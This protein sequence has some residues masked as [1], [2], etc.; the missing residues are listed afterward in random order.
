MSLR[1]LFI[2]G[3]TALGLGMTSAAAAERLTTD[4]VSLPAVTIAPGGAL[5]ARI[6]AS[7]DEVLSVHTILR[8]A[9][10]NVTLMRDR[11]GFWSTWSGDR[12]D[13]V[14][15]AA[16]PEG[17]DLV[18]K[19]FDAPPSAGGAMTITIAYKTKDGLKFGW[20]DVA[21]RAE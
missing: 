1:Y 5:E 9:S 15:S 4:G 2:G 14:P 11:D 20:F 17:D 8:P 12:A 6:D 7:G 18:F 16:R 13:L 3:L 10:S 19:I 21:E